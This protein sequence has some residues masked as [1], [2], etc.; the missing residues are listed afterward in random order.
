MDDLLENVAASRRSLEL[1]F[2]KAVGHG[3]ATEIR[4][5]RL[6]RAF[7]ML[8]VTDL[9]IKQVAA[10]C[11]F[12]GREQTE[13]PCA[14]D[15]APAQPLSRGVSSPRDP[16]A[17]VA[18]EAPTSSSGRVPGRG[19]RAKRNFSEN[20]PCPPST[21][22]NRRE[23][24]PREWDVIVI[25]A[26]V[27]GTFHAYFAARQGLRTLLIE[28][29]DQ[30]QEASVRNFGTL[31]PSAMSP[32][33]WLGGAKASIAIYREL[34]EQVSLPLSCRG[35]QYSTT[36]AEARV[37]EE[38]CGVGPE[39]GYR[40]EFLGPGESVKCNSAIDP[41]TCLGSLDFPD[42]CRIEPR[43]LFRTLIPWISRE[44]GCAY[45]PRTVVVDVAVEGSHCRV[46]VAGGQ[47]FRAGHVFVCGGADLRTL[48]PEK[49]AAAGLVLQ[50]PD[51]PHLA[52]LALAQLGRRSPPACP[53][54][55][56]RRFRSAVASAAP[57]APVDPEVSRRGIHILMVQDA[58]GKVV[59]GDSHEY[60]PGDLSDESDA[61][62]ECDPREARRCAAPDLGSVRAV[63]GDRPRCIPRSRST[64]NRSRG[65]FI[66]SR[67]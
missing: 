13:S 29:G 35:T 21:T 3:P 18:A 59:I 24:A 12:S 66:W 58:N 53:S 16:Y 46:T 20:E 5:T 63:A 33:E 65:G 42:D 8:A 14:G 32:G 51:A 40:C 19:L 22:H 31:V 64:A 52:A 48:F 27:L 23:T 7:D 26:G 56:T 47:E 17:H 55:G 6:R 57:E 60:S 34:A 30:P 9:P 61:V 38:F 36:P 54:A 41:T 62:T 10:R 39:K 4:R 11:G 44:W 67:G 28:R 49:L 50:A 15:I 2:R 37:L 43:G 25:G 1:P 45:L